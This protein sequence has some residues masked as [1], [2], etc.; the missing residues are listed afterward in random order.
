MGKF[1]K[2]VIE[3]YIDGAGSYRHPMIWTF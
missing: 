2:R 1:I 3:A